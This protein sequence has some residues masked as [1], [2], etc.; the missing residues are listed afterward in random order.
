MDLLVQKS[1]GYKHHKLNYIQSLEEGIIPSRLKIKTK[2]AFRP[3]L[4]HVE[5]KWNSILY[6]AERNIV[7]L[8]LYEA[9]KVI[10]KILVEIQEEVYEK[11]PE[12]FE[13]RY[14]ELEGQHSHFQRKLGQKC[15]KKW[16]KV[17]ER[18]I[19]NDEKNN[20]LASTGSNS[21]TSIIQS[22]VVN[23]TK[24]ETISNSL[25]QAGENNIIQLKKGN[26]SFSQPKRTTT[27]KLRNSGDGFSNFANAKLKVDETF[28][29]ENRIAKK[30]KKKSLM[31]KLLGIIIPQLVLLLL[32]CQEFIANY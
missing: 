19:K 28:I 3:V 9:E 18:N 12:K 17:K 23:K 2:P 24:N 8:L 4:E 26:V 6:N 1:L 25:F 31:L 10:T 14:A 11:K 21:S 15:R 7:E 20:I 16:K 32:I 27:E 30:K 5:V 13:R 29:T 22:K